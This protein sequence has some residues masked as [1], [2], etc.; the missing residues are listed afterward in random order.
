MTAVVTLPSVI[1]L[2]QKVRTEYDEL[3]GLNLTRA[4]IQRMWDVDDE[5]CDALLELLTVTHVLRRAPDDTFVA[6]HSAL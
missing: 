6:Y 2:A 3:P 5:A 4:Q 1:A